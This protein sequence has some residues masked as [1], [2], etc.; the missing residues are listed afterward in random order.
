VLPRRAHHAR[1]THQI[2]RAA[3]DRSPLYTGVI[4]G[5]GPR[6][7][8]S[9]E[10]K[11]VRFA[12]RESHQIFV[13]PEGLG[14]RELYPNGI[15]TSLPV[16]V[17]VALVRS[18]PG[19]EQAELTRPGYAVEYDY[20]DPRDLE[21]GLAARPLRGLWLA[22]QINGTTGYEEAAAQGLLAG[23]N[24]A[25]TLNGRPPWTPRRDEA[26]LG[27][28]VDDL[29]THGTREPYRMFTSRA[30]HRLLL[31]EDNADLR[32]TARGRELGLVGDERWAA[33]T[34]RRDALEHLRSA[35]RTARVPA[36][37]ASAARIGALLGTPLERDTTLFDLLRRPEVD[38]ALALQF[39]EDSAAR[40]AADVLRQLEIE[41]KYDGYIE[42]QRVEVERL[43]R[44]EDTPIPADLDYE[45]VAGLSNELREKLATARP[46]N[47][48]R[49]GRIPGMTP[50]ALG[51]LMVHLK[52]R[53]VPLEAAG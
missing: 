25:L 16:D 44:H 30:E 18:I 12:E 35:W 51:V 32:L 7:C 36:G 52:K 42:R 34:A 50:A 33:F 47:L 15:S 28:L 31:R 22:G 41:A 45:A 40:P 48:G 1:Q 49:A 37:S 11:V 26:Y 3:L 14:T 4:E 2:I 19:F 24:A 29:T 10:D 20:L 9:I 38:V 13:E 53:G 17:Q 8:P 21:P 6:Y 39:V 27:V 5:A 23:V 46:G 43:R